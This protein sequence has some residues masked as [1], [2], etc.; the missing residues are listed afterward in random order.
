M[1]RQSLAETILRVDPQFAYARKDLPRALTFG[2][3]ISEALALYEQDPKLRPA[4]HYQAFT[5]VLSGNRAAAERL[6]DA[7]KGFP[8][9][10][11]GIY[12]ALGDMDHAFEALE[13]ALVTDPHRIALHLM[14][15][16]MA[17][18]RADPRY[19]SIRRRLKLP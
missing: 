6:L 17:A 8:I 3:R 9:R 19:A 4:P 7:H 1:L 13:R 14:G 12:I 10:E 11:L 18:V 15:P 5:L 16:E 2:G